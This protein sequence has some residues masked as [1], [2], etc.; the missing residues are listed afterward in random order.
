MQFNALDYEWEQH[1]NFAESRATIYIRR[2][3]VVI[4]EGK[5]R[6]KRLVIRMPSIKRN[7]FNDYHPMPSDDNH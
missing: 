4:C 5:E 6:K 7:D 3:E 2:Y 1:R